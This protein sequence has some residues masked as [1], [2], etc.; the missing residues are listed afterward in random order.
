MGLL[1]AIKSVLGARETSE[2]ESSTADDTPQAS[3]TPAGTASD[4]EPDTEASSG[5]ET[6]VAES[7]AAGSQSP[8]TSGADLTEPD[9]SPDSS[10]SG[11]AE[12]AASGTSDAAA[13]DASDRESGFDH[14]T[15]EPVEDG[16]D[17]ADDAAELITEAEMD[18]TDA[19]EDD[20]QGTGTIPEDDPRV[21]FV[22][23]ATEL[24]EFWGEYELD[25]SLSSLARLDD[26][27]A[28]QWDADRFEDVEFGDD[29]YDAKVYTE[30]ATQLGS[31][32]GEVLVR[33]HDSTWQRETSTGWTV[34]VPS[35]PDSEA[36]GATVSVF[37]VAEDCLT[38]E[39]TFTGMHD[40]LADR[41]NLSGRAGDGDTPVDLDRADIETVASDA[42]IEDAAERLRNGAEDLAERWPDYDL[43]FSVDSLERLDRLLEAELDR[44]RFENVELG[45]ESDRESML[46]TA[47]VVGVAGYLAEVLRRQRD[48]D[49]AEQGRMVLIVAHNDSRTRI[50]P[51]EVAIAAVRGSGSLAASVPDVS[52]DDGLV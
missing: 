17:M 29:S 38:G 8:E 31:Y 4:A 18:D 24:V 3:D 1:D 33:Q 22:D 37:Q 32:F 23:A 45:D 36:A 11:S 6:D 26:L 35:G 49:W 27:V 39:S 51:I 13:E 30:T 42:E 25:F 40:A 43:D 21:E 7:T 15:T 16:P 52:H 48:A 28:E 47:H 46:L 10:G 14:L 34:S 12:M 2:S 19:G 5:A 41:L 20:I 9:S 44:D 50:D